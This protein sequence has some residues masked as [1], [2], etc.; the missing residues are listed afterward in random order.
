MNL[1]NNKNNLKNTTNALHIVGGKLLIIDKI[2]DEINVDMNN[3]SY[4]VCS[5]CKKYYFPN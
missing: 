1:D 2:S 4:I 5:K 3:N